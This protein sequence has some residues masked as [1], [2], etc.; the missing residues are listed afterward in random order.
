[1][2]LATRSAE[3]GDTDFLRVDADKFTKIYSC[4][5]FET[6]APLQ[7]KPDNQRIYVETN[8]DANLISLALL[9]P[10]T[11]KAENVESDPLGKVDFSGALFSEA[12]NELPALKLTT[13]RKR[14]GTTCTGSNASSIT[15]NTR[16]WWSHAPAMRAH[17]W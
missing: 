9:D 15:R 1:L 3:N 17:G 5:V 16:S 7:F 13:R 6:C 14:S 4:N 8:K 2:R 12:T 11:G 10:Q